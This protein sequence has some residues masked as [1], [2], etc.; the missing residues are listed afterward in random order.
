MSG[1][2]IILCLNCGQ[3]IRLKAGGRVDVARCG[4]CRGRKRGRALGLISLLF[5]ASVGVVGYLVYGN[6]LRP[7]N[8]GTEGQHA[9]AESPTFEPVDSL[10]EGSTVP[11]PEPKPPPSFDELNA[12]PVAISTGLVRTWAP[13]S[14][15]PTPSRSAVARS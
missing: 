13:A 4:R 8:T 12:P 11:I 14:R 3:Q 15:K 10:S 5:L 9:K 1:E 6:Q 2:R 7:S